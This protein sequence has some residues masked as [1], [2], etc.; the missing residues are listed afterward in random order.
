MEV[1]DFAGSMW[2]RPASTGGCKAFY[3]PREWCDQGWSVGGKV[4]CVV[5][6]DGGD[7]APLLNLDYQDYKAYNRVDQIFRRRG[8]YAEAV[9]STTTHIYEI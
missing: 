9:D 3:S 7:L 8:I 1:R 4:L 6:H 2:G 5:C